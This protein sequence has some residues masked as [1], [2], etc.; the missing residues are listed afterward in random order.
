MKGASEP[1]NIDFDWVRDQLL[2]RERI[3]SVKKGGPKSTLILSVDKCLEEAGSLILPKSASIE[4]D[5]VRL[6]GNSIGI[7]GGVSLSS[8]W[9]SSYIEGAALMHIFVVTLGLSLEERA[10]RL[11]RDG[12]HLEGYLLDRIGSFAVES[13]A[14]NFENKLRG[15]YGVKDLSVSMR[16]S[17]GYC[18]WRIEEQFKLAKILDF[19]KAGVRLTEGCMMVPKKSISAVVGIGPK[20]LFSK[21]L[22][23]CS[24][25]AKKGDC[26]Y[27]RS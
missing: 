2:K 25:C 3:P 18:D 7:E 22:S 11:M 17:P 15:Y 20:S 5:I 14:E 16:F 6:G 27:R 4:K 12:E 21:K 10:S 24:I 8:K 1:L 19:S 13:L 23:Q 26:S 9:S